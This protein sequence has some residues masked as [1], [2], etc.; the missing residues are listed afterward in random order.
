MSLPA[1]AKE[2][3][4]GSLSDCSISISGTSSGVQIVLSTDATEKADE[5]GCKDIVIQEKV[6]GVWRDINVDD[7]H[8]TNDRHFGGS[9]TY[10]NA[11][12]G[13]TYKAHCTHY[14]KWDGTTKTLYNE[15]STFVYN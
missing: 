14:A 6:N 2:T 5:I 13:R 3:S 7:C 9:A 15:T 11:V 1:N 10:T 8:I 4:D 12:K